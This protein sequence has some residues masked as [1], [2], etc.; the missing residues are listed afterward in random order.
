MIVVL[1]YGREF[2][3]QPSRHNNKHGSN[4]PQNPSARRHLHN[5]Q[6]QDCPRGYPDDQEKSNCSKRTHAHAA[7]ISGHIDLRP[8]PKSDKDRYQRAPA[9]PLQGG[10]RQVLKHFGLQRSVHLLHERNVHQVEEV[11]QPNPR[12]A[13]DKMRPAQK[14]RQRFRWRVIRHYPNG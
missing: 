12:D 2:H 1:A 4:R 11:Q 7:R 5:G 14:Q 3:E 8:V 9:K 10:Q 6:I 13:G